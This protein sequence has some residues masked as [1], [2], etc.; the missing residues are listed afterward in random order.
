MSRYRAWCFTVNNYT[1]EDGSGLQKAMDKIK[2]CVVGKEGKDTETPH[3]QGYIVF[4][5]PITLTALKKK[6]LP[7]AHLESAKGDAEA[8]FNYCSKEGDFVEHG[9]RPSSQAA[10]GAAGK[11][12]W[13][14]IKA[15]A[16]AG[17]IEELDAKTFVQLYPTLKRI[18]KDY[19]TVASDA[20]GCT[21]IWFTGPSGSGKSRTARE[22]Y[23]NA[24]FKRINQWW[25]GYQ[26]Q[27]SVIIDDLDKYHI[28]M[29]HDLKIW[30][31][32]YSFL[33]EVK[34]SAMVIRPKHIVVTSQ[35]GI[36]EIWD[37]LETR[38]ALHRRF[39]VLVF[40]LPDPDPP[41]AT[42]TEGDADTGPAIPYD[43]FN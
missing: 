40:P 11:E 14:N 24:Y 37:D 7:R 12:Y 32:R 42:G 19:M 8:N 31:D 17:Q 30:A 41:S 1:E 15:K 6:Y 21:G 36:N 16:K 38:E 18:E 13:E 2:Y 35:Y 25:D 4:K 26:G 28:K 23:P 20:E 5:E 33:A 34:G 3:M 39:T 22:R 43:I 27:E 9:V 10:K 29:A